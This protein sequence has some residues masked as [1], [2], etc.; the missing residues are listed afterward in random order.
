MDNK[1]SLNL[2]SASTNIDNQVLYPNCSEMV[3]RIFGGFE[4]IRKQMFNMV[5]WVEGEYS[6]KY[7]D[8]GLY[9]KAEP[10]SPKM[11]KEIATLREKI[12][13]AT[14][15]ENFEDLVIDFS[16]NYETF[17]KKENN[18]SLLVATCNNYDWTNVEKEE[19]REG[20]FGGYYG[21]AGCKYFDLISNIDG[22]EIFKRDLNI[23]EDENKLIA[24]ELIFVEKGIKIPKG[25]GYKFVMRRGCAFYISNNKL[26]KIPQVQDKK[27]LNKLKILMNLE[28]DTKTKK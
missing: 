16:F 24:S 22:Y 19:L 17:F 8:Y 5:E 3:F 7:G 14:T 21:I 15:L 25:D 13:N 1:K 9:E 6:G 10:L 20:D 4:E 12:T 2:A 11:K 23:E 18:N 27:I 28:S 26:I